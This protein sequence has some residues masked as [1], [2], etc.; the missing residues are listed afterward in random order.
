MSTL[1]RLPLLTAAE[2]QTLLVARN[3]TATD[4]PAEATLASLFEARVR[5]TPD[6]PALIS[7]EQ[8]L[9]YGELN[10]RA[11]R[12]AHRLR[13]LGVG[14]DRCVGL[15]MRRGRAFHVFAMDHRGVFA[16]QHGWMA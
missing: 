10:A 7:G 11:N 4:Y 9:S 15:C 16:V 6:A 3:D 8:V 1:G 12:L 13:V 5:Q 2:R 14:P